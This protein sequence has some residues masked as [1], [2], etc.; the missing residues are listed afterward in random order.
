M[1]LTQF[2][3]SS[4]VNRCLAPST[5]DPWTFSSSLWIMSLLQQLRSIVVHGFR[6]AFF[7]RANRNDFDVSYVASATVL[8]LIGSVWAGLLLL[9]IHANGESTWL[10]AFGEL[11]R[12]GVFCVTVAGLGRALS[13]RLPFRLLLA[14]L[15]GGL[16]AP[17]TAGQLLEYIDRYLWVSLSKAPWPE[18]IAP[19]MFGYFGLTILYASV[20]AWI[21]LVLYRSLRLIAGP[22][23]VGLAI[24]ITAILGAVIAIGLIARP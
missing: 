10:D 19:A 17:D 22:P 1:K 13:R 16:L 8:V 24:S 9:V 23:T 15:A 5:I 3:R 7:L 14:T 12:P 21:V 4:F 6:L 18:G 2:C 11:L 20:V